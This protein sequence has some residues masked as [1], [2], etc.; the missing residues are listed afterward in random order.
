MLPSL[1][2]L[3]VP[4]EHVRQWAVPNAVAQGLSSSGTLQLIS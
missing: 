2:V 4:L 3:C 1:L